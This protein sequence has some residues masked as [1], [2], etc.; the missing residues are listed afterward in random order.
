MARFKRTRRGKRSKKSAYSKRKKT[1]YKRGSFAKRVRSVVLKTCETKH[2]NYNF[3]K[4]EYYHNIFITHHLNNMSC[5]PQQESGSM[6]RIGDEINVSGWMV[7]MMLG[8][9]ADRPNVSW[10]YLV[11]KVPKNTSYVYGNWF[12]NITNNILLDPVNKR[13]VTV[14]ASGIWK[15]T[16]TSLEVGETPKEQTYAHKLWIP[17]KKTIKFGPSEGALPIT[18]PFDVYMLIAAFDAYGTL[19]TDNIGYAQTC[20]TIYYKDP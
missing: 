8:Q 3:G 2:K 15:H 4:N 18:D 7:R 13:L 10:R 6:E 16:T 17:Y 9:K 1:S 5:M 19:F 11:V 20:S 14:L 12:E